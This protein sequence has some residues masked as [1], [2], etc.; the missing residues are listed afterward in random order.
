LVL[1][2][3]KILTADANFS[4]AQAVAIRGNQIAAVGNDAD[5][6]KLAGPSSQVIDLKGR[7]VIPGL[8]DTHRHISEEAEANYGAAVGP[9][10]LQQYV[11]DWR[12]A[13]SKQDVLNQIKGLMDKYKFKPGEWI[14]FI[15]RLSFMGGSGASS[16]QNVQ[17]KILFDELGRKDLDSVTPNNPAAFSEGIP[18]D[19]GLFVNSKGWDLIMAKHGDMIKK[20][21]R[22]WIDS[23]GQPDGHLEP[24]ATRIV[25]NLLP[26]PNPEAIAPVYKQTLEELSSMGLTGISTWLPDYSAAAYQVLE[27]KGQMTIRMAYGKKQIF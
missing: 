5:V 9:A 15:N 13:T 12:G 16:D 19:N 17:S 8:I 26:K 11:V 10:A 6:M 3:G 20:Y 14:Y 2:N 25:L 18:E 22:F 27:S 4:V 1:H 21:G 7:T 24:P 23:A